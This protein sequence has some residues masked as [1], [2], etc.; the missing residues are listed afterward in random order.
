MSLNQRH[1]LF[2]SVTIGLIVFDLSLWREFLEFS[3][4]RSNSH[5]THLVLIPFVTAGLIFMRRERIFSSVHG[6]P[7]IGCL[8]VMFGILLFAAGKASV[9]EARFDDRLTLRVL[10]VVVT[11]IGAFIL[12]YGKSSLQS[13]VFPLLFLI[14]MVPIPRF[15][16]ERIISVLLKGSTESASVFLRLSG[17][18]FYRNGSFFSLPGLTVEVAEECSGIRSG[19]ALFITALLA[20]YMFLRSPWKRIILLLFVYPIAV[21]KNGLRIAMLTLMAVHIDPRILTSSLHREGGIPFFLLALATLAPILLL[22]RRS[23][24]RVA[25]KGIARD[26]TTVVL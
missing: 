10:S 23:E 19:I 9:N 2:A 16:L 14:L 26:A 11:W 17:T 1:V 3:L 20:G 21:A 7:V 4:N 12:L 6:S 15:L 25:K 22:L 18:P 24:T 8:V 5:A 13:A